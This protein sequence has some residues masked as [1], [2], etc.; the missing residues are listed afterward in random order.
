M[1]DSTPVHCT[2][3]LDATGTHVGRLEL[4]RSTNTSGDNIVVVGREIDLSE[5]A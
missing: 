5:L 3:D 1:D 4:P 2:L